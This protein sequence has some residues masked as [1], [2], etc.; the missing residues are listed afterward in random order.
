M[1]VK[2]ELQN[3]WDTLMSSLWFR[4][5]II[6]VSLTVSAFITVALDRIVDDRSF[7][8]LQASVDD[9]R[10]IL[11]AII[12]SMLTVTTVTFSIIMVA[13]VLASQQFSPRIIRNFLRDAPFQHVLGIFIG[14][15]VHSLLVLA[16]TSSIENRIFVPIISMTFSVILTLTSI[17]AFIYFIH[18][19]SEAIQVNIIIARSAEKTLDVVEKHFPENL[20]HA[21]EEHSSRPDY[22]HGTPLI[23]T[24]RI[25]GYIQSVDSVGLLDLAQEYDI[26]IVMERAI[27]DFVP[28]GNPLLT[29]WPAKL[30]STT[31]VN[32]LQDSYEIGDERTLFDDV[33][34]GLRQLVDVAL[35]AISPAVNDPSTAVTCLDH[36]A[37]ILVQA[38]R[39]PDS[40]QYRYDDDGQLR[41]V[42]RVVDFDQMLAIS[43]NQIRQYAT[44]DVAVTLRMLEVLHEIGLATTD[45]ARRAVIWRHTQMIARGAE[46][47]II[48]PFDRELINDRITHLAQLFDKPVAM[49]LLPVDAMQVAC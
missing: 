5:T 38:A 9:A 34:F 20:G 48:E 27:G 11:S 40:A 44:S 33:L 43:F 19:V 28:C 22:T 30:L 16:Q 41:V 36:L 17:V 15:F 8:F 39:R 25:A 32:A 49:L 45:S 31:Q 3:R 26:V 18:H 21:A 42:A 47:G 6:T 12:S 7:G 2:L 10:A 35:K 4:P 14:T 24:S 46:R 1:R 29:V 13:L 23:I 37:N